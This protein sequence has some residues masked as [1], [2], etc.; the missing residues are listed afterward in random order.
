LA[1]IAAKL[2]TGVKLFDL[3]L[4]KWDSIKHIAVK[5][6][7]LPFNKFPN[8]AIFLGPE[9]KST[10]EVMGI[11]NSFGQSFLRASISAGNK[12]P[13]TGTVFVSVNDPDKMNVINIVRDLVEFGFDIIATS[14]TS[15]ELNKNGIQTKTIYKV[16]EG[17]PNIVDAIKNNDIKLVINTPAG[18]KSRFDEE[19][20]GRACIRKGILVI[21][22]LSGAEAAVRAIRMVERD[23]EVKSIQEF[24]F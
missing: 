5:E 22:T 11:S 6:A 7:V 13:N 17:R 16:G 21:T 10:G 20:I 19:A 14:G 18:S 15:T 8:E 1:R 9:M 24:H 4:P 23:I 2:T 12:I 3:E